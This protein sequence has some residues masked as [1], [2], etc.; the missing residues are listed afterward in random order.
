MTAREDDMFAVARFQDTLWVLL[1]VRVPPTGTSTEDAY[2]LGRAFCIEGNSHQ[3][4]FCKTSRPTGIRQIHDMLTQ[5][6]NALMPAD[7]GTLWSMAAH[8][9][10]PQ[11]AAALRNMLRVMGL[12][13][14]PTDRGTLHIVLAARP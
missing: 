2:V 6:G 7:V 14:R 13:P 10:R 4:V 5:R 3:E 1:F 12:E 9:S 8:A 11:V